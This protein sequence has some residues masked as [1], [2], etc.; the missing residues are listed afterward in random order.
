M[1]EFNYKQVIYAGMI[2]IASVDGKISPVE[3]KAMDTVYDKFITI[4]QKEKKEVVAVYER[5]NDSFV[6]VFV[7]ELKAFPKMDQIEAYTY[8]MKFISFSKNMYDKSNTAIPKGVDPQRVEFQLYYDR[9]NE[10]LDKLDFSAEEYT[11]ATSK[12][13]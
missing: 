3:K 7:E 5:K 13:K 8:I 4:P 12:R 9:A 11:M 1:A 6:D 10:I 2:S